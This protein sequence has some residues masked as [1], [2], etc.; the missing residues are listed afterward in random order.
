MDQ[1]KT[2][3][4]GRITFSTLVSEITDAHL[5]NEQIHLELVLSISYVGLTNY[6]EKYKMVAKQKSFA[7]LIFSKKI[8]R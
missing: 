3:Y 2:P 5:R 8:V 7:D 6:A 1:V 4:N